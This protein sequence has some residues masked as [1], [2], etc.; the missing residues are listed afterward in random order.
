VWCNGVP[1]PENERALPAI[2]A[3]HGYRTACLGKAHFTPFGGEA[4]PGY[5]DNGR[6]WQ[7]HDLS[8]WDGPYYGFEFVR[9]AIGHVHPHAGHYGLWLR[10]QYPELAAEYANEGRTAPRPPSRPAQTW[11]SVLTPEAHHSTWVADQTL[12]YLRQRAADGQPFFAW[13]SFP[14]PHHP[15][16]P[17]A[18]YARR[19]ADAE[20]RMPA[21]RPGELADKPP[22]FQQASDPGLRTEGTGPEANA[23]TYTD[24]Q[25]RDILRYTYAMIELVDANIGRILDALDALGLR[26][27]TIVAFASDHGDLLGDHGLINKGPFHYE[28]LVRVPWLWRLPAAAAGHA[29]RVMRRESADPQPGHIT[30]DTRHTTGLSALC[31]FAD[32]APTVLDLLG[33]PLGD[34]DD[35]GRAPFDFQGRS[36]APLLRGETDRHRDAVLIENQSRYRPWLNLK[37]LRTADWKLTYYAGQSYGELYD[38]RNDPD[39][40]VNRY[41]DP[42]YAAIRAELIEQ[43]VV[44]LVATESRTPPSRVHA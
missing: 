9:L 5:Y 3:E 7:E 41:D 12:E 28:G 2:L 32:F 16:R 35:Q 23:G 21:R 4:L 13:T 25:I 34:Y 15:F 18:E 6:M 40:F 22:H 10:E 17:P 11:Q 42:D 37:T 43:L 33:I 1:L 27:S 24:E 39:E 36:F 30:H 19:W 8:G 20:V 44:E 38:M 26:D 29:S 14:D 31:C